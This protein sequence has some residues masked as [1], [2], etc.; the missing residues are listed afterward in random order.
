ML[1]HRSQLLPFSRNASSVCCRYSCTLYS[2]VFH[3][4]SSDLLHKSSFLVQFVWFKYASIFR[5]YWK[6]SSLMLYLHHFG[7]ISLLNGILSHFY[8]SVFAF[9]LTAL[10]CRYASLLVDCILCFP[11]T[12]PMFLFFHFIVLSSICL[13]LVFRPYVLPDIIRLLFYWRIGAVRALEII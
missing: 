12:F 4:S 3:S 8:C 9:L 6:K 1:Y 2:K 13:I 5:T 11:C 10:T 7:Y